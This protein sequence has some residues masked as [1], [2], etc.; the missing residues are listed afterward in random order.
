MDR[1]TERER[2]KNQ[3]ELVKYLFVTFKGFFKLFHVVTFT[4]AD[5][6]K[7]FSMSL[8][9]SP[10]IVVNWVH[11]FVSQPNCA[12][13]VGDAH[14]GYTTYPFPEVQECFCLEQCTNMFHK[15]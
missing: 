6:P 15:N 7:D 10:F 9:V 5:K 11:S 8:E 14:H 12:L 4:N 2:E 1:Q 13:L 3:N